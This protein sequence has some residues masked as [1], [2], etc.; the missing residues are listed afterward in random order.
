MT[1]KPS[2]KWARTM[3]KAA[4]ELI[5][6]YRDTP[7]QHNGTLPEDCPLCL[8]SNKFSL[9]ASAGCQP[10]PWVMFNKRY[11]TTSKFSNDPIPKR[12]HR[13]YGW[14]RRF[15]NYLD[16]VGPLARGGKR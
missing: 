4:E 13:L 9:T 5:E 10:C 1:F 2:K 15:D 11:C 14:I 8:M 3:K 12:L 7:L 6:D 16:G